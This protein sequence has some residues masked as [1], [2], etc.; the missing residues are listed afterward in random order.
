MRGRG[1]YKLPDRSVEKYRILHVALTSRMT[2]SQT[3]RPIGGSTDG[4]ITLGKCGS[5]LGVLPCQEICRSAHEPPADAL[6]PAF[7]EFCV[8][9][10]IVLKTHLAKFGR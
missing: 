1:S 5:S 10:C 6:L 7:P 4:I 3:L 8:S 2:P 9:V